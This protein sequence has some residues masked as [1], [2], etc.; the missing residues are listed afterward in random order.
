MANPI[1]LE[2]RPP[3][4]QPED[5]DALALA[6]AE[7]E[8]G[9]LDHRDYAASRLRFWT[10]VEYKEDRERAKGEREREADIIRE[11]I[12]EARKQPQGVYP[13]AVKKAR[14]YCPDCPSRN[15]VLVSKPRNP[16]TN[17]ASRHRHFTV[18]GACGW[19]MRQEKR[20][21]VIEL[22]ADERCF[23]FC[24]NQGEWR[25]TRISF[26][27]KLAYGKNSQFIF[28]KIIRYAQ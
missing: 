24:E 28:S 19:C 1:E 13:E 12:I 6:D 15:L 7:K 22:E 21:A 11:A 26:D 8:E 25:C 23:S 3:P 18:F 16:D 20:Q 5:D 10:V 4:P 14:G 17:A 9:E 2:V 27:L